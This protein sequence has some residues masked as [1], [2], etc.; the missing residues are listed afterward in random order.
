[1]ARGRVRSGQVPA[2][3]EAAW[4]WIPRNTIWRA[5]AIGLAGLFLL[6]PLALLVFGALGIDRLAPWHFVYYKAGFAALEGLLVTPL[7]ALWAIADPPAKFAAVGQP[8]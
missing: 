1:M 5:L 2:A 3:A 7:L 6:T 4:K 8:A